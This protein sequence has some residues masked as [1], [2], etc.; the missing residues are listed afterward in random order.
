MN[1]LVREVYDPKIC[2]A[3]YDDLFKYW[4]AYYSVK[5]KILKSMAY[6]ESHYD[7]KAPGAAGEVGLMQVLPDTASYFGYLPD[8]LEDPFINIECGAGHLKDMLNRYDG[9]YKKAISAYRAGS[10]QIDNAISI[11]GSDWFK[12]TTK[13]TQSYYPGVVNIYKRLLQCGE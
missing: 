8:Q 3:K 13:L 1:C 4:S 5:W 9:D 10:M 12:H 2:H 11:Y 6:K 7:P